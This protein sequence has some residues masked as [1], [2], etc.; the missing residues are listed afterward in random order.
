MYLQTF[1]KRRDRVDEFVVDRRR[2]EVEQANPLEAVDLVQ[3]LEQPREAAAAQAAIAAPHR[4]VLRD[5][6]QLFGA[7][8]GERAR[9]CEDRLLAAAAEGAAQLRDD[10]ERARMVAAFGDLQIGRGA[11]RRDQARQKVVLGFGFEVRANGA[12]PGFDVVEQL[13]DA[14]RTRPC[15]RRRRFRG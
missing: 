3:A 13:D 15:R 12:P 1:G 4:R 2:I 7:S 5:Q 6:D 14:A 8:G 11:R 9:F 10:A